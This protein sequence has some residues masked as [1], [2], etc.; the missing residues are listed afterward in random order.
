MS[1]DLTP[2]ELRQLAGPMSPDACAAVFLLRYS[3]ATR[4]AYAC[5]LGEW[6]GWL[7]RINVAPFDAHRS[8]V[9]LW[10]RGLEERRARS[11]VARKLCSVAGFY[12]YA[13]QE[14]LVARDPC[15]GVRRPKSGGESPS[16][17]LDRGEL[18]ALLSAAEASGERTYAL[19][20]LMALSG[21]RV[22]ESLSL[23]VG[24]LSSERGHRTVSVKRKGG[25]RQT[26][27]LAPVTWEAIERLVAGRSE[28]PVFRTLSGNRLDR[29]AATKAIS[30]LAELAG[31]DKH[32]SAH[33][34]RHT[35]VSL[36]LDAGATL[37][38]VQT[39]AGHAD[40]KTTVGYD[41]AIRSLDRNP[42]FLIAA[43]I[44]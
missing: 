31:I 34:L 2:S 40:P 20:L 23:D 39:A 18:R 25:S 38:D 42:T 35:F 7:Q 22:S 11:T 8:H 3:G 29:W 9:E 5:D 44:A 12:R 32:I 30:R 41:R 37:R 19:T 16:T 33:S 43:V 28:G 36:A 6:A 14:G 17:G 26:L 24:H 10:Q 1:T 4:R 15:V 13:F 21:L 27:P